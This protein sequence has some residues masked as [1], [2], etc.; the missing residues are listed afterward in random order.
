MES[1]RYKDY[2]ENFKTQKIKFK[3][4]GKRNIFVLLFVD[5]I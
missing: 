2:E 4:L 1:Q 3:I 5:N